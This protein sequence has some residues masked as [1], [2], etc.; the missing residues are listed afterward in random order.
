VERPKDF[1]CYLA[2]G[3]SDWQYR[4]HMVDQTI[5]MSVS[6]ILNGNDKEFSR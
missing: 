6:E 3:R 4:I 2:L 5:K 1:L